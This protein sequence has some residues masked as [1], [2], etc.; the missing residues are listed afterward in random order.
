MIYFAIMLLLER[1]KQADTEY[2][3]STRDTFV[4]GKLILKFF[5]V[6]VLLAI[7]CCIEV[8]D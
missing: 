8:T 7:S 4:I 1:K 5:D 6:N 2:S 3:P